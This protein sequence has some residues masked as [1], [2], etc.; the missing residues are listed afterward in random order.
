METIFAAF[1]QYE[2]DMNAYRTMAA[3][4]QNA[5]EGN[6]NGAVAPFGFQITK[7]AVGKN[8]RSRLVPQTEEAL[9]GRMLFGLWIDGRGS[10]AVA[11]ELNRRGIEYRGRVWTKDDVLRVIGEEAAA[12]T[13]YW[14]KWDTSGKKPRDRS[15]WIP[16]EV[17]GFV[18]RDVC[19]MAQTI[20]ERRDPKTTPGRTPSSPLLLAGLI[21]CGSCG[22]SFTK[23]SSGKKFAGE[24]P[25]AYY[26]CRTFT[27]IG[28]SKCKGKRVRVNV[29]DRL[30]VDHLADKLFTIERC[31]ALVD[32]L[33]EKAG[34]LRR[35]ADDRRTGVRSQ[36]EGIER[37]IARWESAFETGKQDLDV[38]APRL[39]ELREQHAKLSDVLAQLKPLDA[40]PKHLR[41]DATIARFQAVIRDIFIS[42]DTPV[43]KNY[44][45][46]LIDQVV[47]HHDRI[48][49]KAK[50]LNA[51]AFMAAAPSLQP[52][53]V[54]HP[55]AV[56]TKGGDWLRK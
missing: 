34:V 38:V 50:P 31:R 23:E 33:T 2:S 39:R 43:T 25:H 5:R 3:M 29:L 22:A 26:N 10:K 37:R 1:D 16:L 14:G 36:L 4:Q 21:K 56:L 7:V 35:K 9:V 54:N 19:D 8:T 51:L 44:L 28:K 47:V 40:P 15:E 17:E 46:F 48:E 52:Q 55:E 30:I 12:G 24:H 32:A 18:E 6:F 13:Y 11:A 45:N 41:D 42:A 53:D 49:I 27:R 20:R